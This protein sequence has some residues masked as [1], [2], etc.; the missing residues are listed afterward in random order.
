MLNR[1]PRE[2]KYKH[3]RILCLP[4]YQ[5]AIL[6][7]PDLVKKEKEQCSTVIEVYEYFLSSTLFH[8]YRSKLWDNRLNTDTEREQAVFPLIH[9]K[10][11][12]STPNTQVL[13]EIEADFTD[14]QRIDNFKSAL[15]ACAI[16]TKL[17]EE[18]S[19]ISIALMK[20]DDFMIQSIVKK[21]NYGDNGLQQFMIKHGLGEGILAPETIEITSYGEWTVA[22]NARANVNAP[23]TIS[24]TW[25]RFQENLKA[26]DKLVYAQRDTSIYSARG[27]VMSAYVQTS[28]EDEKERN[29]RDRE[30]SM[31]Q[32][33]RRVRDNRAYRHRANPKNE[34]TTIPETE[35]PEAA[36]E[37]EMPAALQVQHPEP[38]PTAKIQQRN[39]NKQLQLISSRNSSSCTE[40]TLSPQ[41]L[42]KFSTRK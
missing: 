3:P 14:V 10:Q 39:P 26:M 4:H 24:M 23:A 9:L 19:N 40:P 12:R 28:R 36:L 33:E 11:L 38:T 5:K 25:S 30:R 15:A 29:L 16:L 13:K 17:Q 31:E 41:C 20:T 1:R 8:E 42:A 32:R 34:A 22:N 7:Y 6:D 18:L 27:V 35:I 21:F 37:T 2:P